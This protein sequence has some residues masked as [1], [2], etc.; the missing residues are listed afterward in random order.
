MVLLSVLFCD[1]TRGEQTVKDEKSVIA[2]TVCVVSIQPP[3][4][5]SS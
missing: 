3:T 1:N 5:A 4:M 2:A